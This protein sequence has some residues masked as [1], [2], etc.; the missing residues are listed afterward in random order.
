[1]NDPRELESFGRLE[2]TIKDFERSSEQVIKEIGGMDVPT[3][4]ERLR[5]VTEFLEHF[6]KSFGSDDTPNSNQWCMSMLGKLFVALAERLIQ[7]EIAIPKDSDLRTLIPRVAAAFDK[8]NAR[9]ITF[10]DAFAKFEQ[11]ESGLTN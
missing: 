10:A 8:V 9:N 6:S 5:R 7:L 2:E 11:L 4:T 1:M 3:L